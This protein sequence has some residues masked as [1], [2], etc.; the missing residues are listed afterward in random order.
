MTLSTAYHKHSQQGPGSLDTTHPLLLVTVCA[1]YGNN[2]NRNVRAVERTPQNVLYFSSFVA[3]AWLN[4]LEDISQD[5]RSLNTANP[6][7]LVNIYAKYKENRSRTVHAVELTQKCVSVQQFCC[8]VMAEWNW[9]Y[10]SKSQVI[11]H[12]AP[13]HAGDICT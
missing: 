1:K 12:N 2:P 5:Q 6:P 3:Y 4:D 9:R 8:K 7:M 10:R 11:V 13:S